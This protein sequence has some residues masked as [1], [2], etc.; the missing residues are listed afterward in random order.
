MNA[1]IYARYSSDKQTENSIDFQLRA[2]QAY[3]E[4]KG[5]KIVGEYIDRA[6]SGTTDDRPEFQRMIED[7]KKRQFAYIIVYRFD[8]FARNRYD[9]AIYKKELESY[10][11]R[12]LST[13]ESIGT[14]D[15]GIILESIYEAM[16][17]SYSR[18]LSRV[19]TQGMRETAR[20][21]LS[22]GGNLSLGLK[23]VD[24]KV[25]LDERYIPAI[26]YCFEARAEGITK[27]PIAKELNARGFRTKKG[28]LFTVNTISQ[29]L[30]NP[31]YKG[32][33]NYAGIERSCPAAVSTELWDRV[34]EIEK[35]DKKSYGKKVSET[36]YALSGKIFCG[37]CGASLIG[38]CG[39]SGTGE[40]YFYYSCSTRKKSRSCKKKSEKKDFIE[41]Y[42]CEQTVKFVLTDANIKRIAE[43]VVALSEE[44]LGSGELS[45]LEKRLAEIEREID[46]AA[47]SLMKTN[48]T[49]L[50]KRINE[51]VAV[52]EAQQNATE[53][54]ISRLRV[55]Q[56][57]RVTV[58]EVEA[59]LRGFCSGDLFDEAF[60]RRLI[61]T[62]VNCIY[63]F[64]DKVVIYY[65][66]RGMKEVS[67]IEMLADVEELSENGAPC[68]SDSSRVGSPNPHLSEHVYFIFTG[69]CFGA[70]IDRS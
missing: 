53:T 50:I 31:V 12:V 32:V 54:E 27:T 46:A 36:Y 38:D 63:L 26:R 2:D 62:L 45:R 3:C 16:A 57:L 20:K 1:V 68:G 7:A 21:G 67:Y 58:R 15:E 70:V 51:K 34:Q 61:K 55:R 14:G 64:D 49:A 56:E 52:L 48:S 69:G 23:I 30:A 6:V 66:V 28:G 41:W 60:R 22:T 37:H 11:V 17:E 40:K 65:N 42:I 13:E 10:G 8:R 47:D 5:L 19:V 18:R 43:R 59:F 35:R 29:I 44:E 9:S 25:E 33:H 4:T 39:T 24:H